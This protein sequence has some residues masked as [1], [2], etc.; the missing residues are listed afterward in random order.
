MCQQAEPLAAPAVSQ[1]VPIW[2]QNL[3]PTKVIIAVGNDDR[4]AFAYLNWGLA[5]GHAH[6]PIARENALLDRHLD[7]AVI[8]TT[9]RR[10]ALYRCLKRMSAPRACG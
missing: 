8:P 9:S 5:M 6:P 7:A 2:G 3:P 4:G 1:C 10:T